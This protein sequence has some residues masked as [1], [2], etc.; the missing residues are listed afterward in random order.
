MAGYGR[1][2]RMVGALA[3]V[4]GLAAAA[5]AEA[6]DR[7]IIGLRL[8]MAVAEV[9]AA[10]TAYDPAITI[11]EHWQYFIYSDG[12]NHGLQTKAFLA[13]IDAYRQVISGNHWGSEGISVFFSSPPEEARV[14]AVTRTLDNTPDPLTSQQ[15]RE[16]LVA[17][18]G[19]PASESSHEVRWLF[20]EGKV[21][22]VLNSGS[23]HPTH[24]DFLQHV[25]QGGIAGRMNNPQAKDLSDCA[26]YLVYRVGTGSLPASSV[27]A[28]M[29]DV[30]AKAGSEL[31]A[32]DWVDALAEAARKARESGATA[33][34]L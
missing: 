28:L 9:K 10:L 24:D 26:A 33:P 4:A 21:D 14:V 22:C 13:Y 20:P 27:T 19:A 3:V 29:V 23:Y 34:K 30:A 15:F 12:I 2:G 5:P 1:L 31:A 25:F 7:D 11:D 6:E 8:G 32:N 17:K 18:Y 16:A